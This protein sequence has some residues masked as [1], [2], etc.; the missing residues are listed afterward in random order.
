M[1]LVGL[2]WN[3]TLKK[4][5]F[6]RGFV[7]YL[8]ANGLNPHCNASIHASQHL[9]IGPQPP[10]MPALQLLADDVHLLAAAGFSPSW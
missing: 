7:M 6:S 10:S 9:V 3:L 8:P 4:L 2:L 5:A 1:C